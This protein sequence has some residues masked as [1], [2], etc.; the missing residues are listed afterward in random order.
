MKRKHGCAR[1]ARFLNSAPS[2]YYRFVRY[3][4][5]GRQLLRRLAKQGPAPGRR[6]RR[7]RCGPRSPAESHGRRRRAAETTETGTST[8]P[9]ASPADKTGNR[10]IPF[11][12]AGQEGLQMFRDHGVESR[13]TTSSAERLR[14]D[15]P[16]S[17]PQA[18][19]RHPGVDTYR[20]R[21]RLRRHST[22]RK[23]RHWLH[24]SHLEDSGFRTRSFAAPGSRHRA[25]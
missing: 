4:G 8:A 17:L 6:T 20:S 1:S 7:S 21:L 14:P 2:S 16:I 13:P 3:P 22:G 11:L 25:G 19:H 18:E 5:Q 12:L 15:R 24:R 9:R 10:P 23:R